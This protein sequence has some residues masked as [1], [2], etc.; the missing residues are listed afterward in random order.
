VHANRSLIH[1]F[2]EVPRPPRMIEDHLLVKLVE[3]AAH[4]K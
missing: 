1:E 4:E 3:F 2:T